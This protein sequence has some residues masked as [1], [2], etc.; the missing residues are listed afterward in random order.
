MAIQRYWPTSS[1]GGMTVLAE[2]SDGYV[3][4][5]EHDAEVARLTRERDEAEGKAAV[6]RLVSAIAGAALLRSVNQ[7][8]TVQWC[9]ACGHWEQSIEAIREHVQTCP[10]HPL[11]IARAEIDRLLAENVALRTELETICGDC[12]DRKQAAALRDKVARLK[13]EGGFLAEYLRHDEPDVVKRWYAALS[14]AEW[15]ERAHRV[16]DGTPG[17]RDMDAAVARDQTNAEDEGGES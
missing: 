6:A 15:G 5:K 10:S 2:G 4:S 14:E 11:A 1:H 8:E 13:Y 17:V 16:P 3:E 7:G 9:S 12:P